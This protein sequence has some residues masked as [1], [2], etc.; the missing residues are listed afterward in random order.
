MMVHGEHQPSALAC[1]LNGSGGSLV[2][3][4]VPCPGRFGEGEQEGWGTGTCGVPSFLLAEH[5]V[6]LPLLAPVPAL[7][8]GSL[9]VLL[10]VPPPFGG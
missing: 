2:H 1:L 6:L 8:V 9:G 5:A 4:E 10:F 7:V 3:P